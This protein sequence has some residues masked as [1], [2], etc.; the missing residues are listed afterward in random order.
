M[1][2]KKGQTNNPAG[3]RPGIPNKITTSTKIWIQNLIDNHRE[4]LEED[5]KKLKPAE[6]WN[7]IERLL[8]YTTPKMGQ[9]QAQIDFNN[10]DEEQI[11][12]VVGQILNNLEE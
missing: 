8:Q 5:L 3:R 6:R 12:S 11:N 1:G 10:L 9:V 2:L 7:V 4:T